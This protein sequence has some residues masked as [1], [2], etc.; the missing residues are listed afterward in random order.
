MRLRVRAHRP[1]LLRGEPDCLFS[2]IHLFVHLLSRVF[3]K[4]DPQL[5]PEDTNVTN[6]NRNSFH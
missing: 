1:C 3:Y 2:F 6:K 4:L 5:G